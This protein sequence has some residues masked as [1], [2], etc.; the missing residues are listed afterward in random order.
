MGT[1]FYH[2]IMIDNSPS[3]DIN[4]IFYDNA[5]HTSHM[6]VNPIPASDPGIVPD[7]HIGLNHI[8][9]PNNG[10]VANH[11]ISSDVISLAQTGVLKNAGCLMDKFDELPAPGNDLL[12]T[13]PTRGTAY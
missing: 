8:I 2:D 4:I 10:V 6:C 3:M 1:G 5:P 13:L 7:N 11:G 12:H 9:I